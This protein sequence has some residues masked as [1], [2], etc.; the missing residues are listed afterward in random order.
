MPG[1]I[2]IGPMAVG[3]YMDIGVGII[4]ALT[5]KNGLHHPHVKYHNHNKKMLNKAMQKLIKRILLNHFRLYN[6]H[7]RELELEKCRHYN[8]FNTSTLTRDLF[9]NYS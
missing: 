8:W 4:S 1:L 6:I 9:K 3:E 7:P 2:M 5:L